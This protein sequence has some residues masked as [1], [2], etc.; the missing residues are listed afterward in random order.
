V[1]PFAVSGAV[2]RGLG[3]R[4]QGL[5]LDWSCVVWD[6]DFRH[7]SE[8]WRHYSFVG[9]RWNQVRKPERQLYMKNAYRVLLTRSRQGRLG[10]GQAREEAQLDECRLRVRDHVAL[11]VTGRQKEGILGVLSGPERHKQLWPAGFS[12]GGV[13]SLEARRR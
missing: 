4:A 10:V 1:S 6:A 9:D 7:D 8:G 13:V 5:E 11:S 3:A 12:R 2:A